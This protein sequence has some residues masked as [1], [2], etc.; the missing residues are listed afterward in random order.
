VDD[1]KL[2]CSFHD[3]ADG[4]LAQPIMQVRDIRQ[5]HHFNRIKHYA[6]YEV[7]MQSGSQY[8]KRLTIGSMINAFRVRKEP[9]GVGLLQRHTWCCCN[10]GQYQNDLANWIGNRNTILEYGNT[11]RWNENEF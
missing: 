6:E 11:G 10:F 2:G 4:S 9:I 1:I 7:S 5:E 3:S 8:D